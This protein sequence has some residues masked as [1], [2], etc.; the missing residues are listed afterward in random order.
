VSKRIS[1]F[2][3]IVSGDDLDGRQTLDNVILKVSGLQVIN[4]FLVVRGLNSF[5]NPV[6]DQNR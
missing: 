3:V 2:S 1:P 4:G 5:N 6:K